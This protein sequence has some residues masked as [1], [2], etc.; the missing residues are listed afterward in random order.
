MYLEKLGYRDRGKDAYV[1][2][3]SCAYVYRLESQATNPMRVVVVLLF[4]S[5]IV[6][7]ACVVGLAG[8]SGE[9][10]SS[11]CTPTLVDMFERW[12]D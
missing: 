11:P 12:R 8:N 3:S 6:V 9:K 2:G 1:F 4:W 7:C 5:V 10:M